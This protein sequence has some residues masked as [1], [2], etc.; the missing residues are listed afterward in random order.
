[1]LPIKE[2]NVLHE[3]RF[4]AGLGLTGIVAESKE[5]FVCNNVKRETRF[6]PDIDNLLNIPEPQNIM[7]G[8]LLGTDN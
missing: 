1:L 7:L 5:T 4:P 6:S 3:I 8:A 2:E